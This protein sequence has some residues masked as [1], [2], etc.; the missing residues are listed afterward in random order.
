MAARGLD[1]SG[2]PFVVNFDIPISPQDYIHRVGRTGRAGLK[3]I[4]FSFVGAS[5]VMINFNGKFVEHNENHLLR[6][7]QKFLTTEKLYV[8]KVLIN[9]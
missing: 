3:G 7:I 8:K 2:L 9:Y 4:A 1:V 5:P 6:K